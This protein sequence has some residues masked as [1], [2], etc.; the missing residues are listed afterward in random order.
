MS[1]GSARNISYCL[2][3]FC[4][5]FTAGCGDSEHDNTNDLE[6]SPSFDERMA[7]SVPAEGFGYLIDSAVTG[8]RYRS[9]EHYGL[10]DEN[11]RFGYRFGED[12]SFYIGDILL[13]SVAMPASRVTP[14]DLSGEHA[15]SALNIAR[16]LQSL[17][18]DANAD[19]GIEIGSWVHS[20]AE[21]QTLDFA[22]AAWQVSDFPE[23]DLID[24][25]LV[26]RRSHIEA[27]VFAL[28]T[29][30]DAGA[31]YLVTPGDAYT[32]LA[33]THDNYID[34]L[35]DEL[36]ALAGTGTCTQHSDC[37]IGELP[38]SA[39]GPCPLGSEYFAYVETDT[40]MTQLDTL[41]AARARHIR[42]KH[43]L[44]SAAF[45]DKATS[46]SCLTQTITPLA[47]CNAQQRC[48]VML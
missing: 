13:G 10:T 45:T 33:Q 30:T 41:L 5:L 14:Y 32:H 37:I 39:R 1:T 18:N 4:L 16:F 21:G 28:T 31:R 12:V 19:N 47:Q 7:L 29:V 44:A 26:E 3:L 2:S 34:T 46:G 9:G 40:A 8:V 11:G 24:G 42:V 48:S 15:E 20:E 22:H 6:A 43:A 38:N 27:L 17:D 36:R 35:A 25:A 23:Y